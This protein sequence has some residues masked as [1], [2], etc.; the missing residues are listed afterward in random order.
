MMSCGICSK[1]QH[2]SCHDNADL[3][4]G[5]RKRNWDIEEFICQHCRPQ[6]YSSSHQQYPS[7][8]YSTAHSHAQQPQTGD[9]MTYANPTTNLSAPRAPAGYTGVQAYA[10]TIPS[11]QH[12]D[13]NFRTS[14][15]TSMSQRPYQAHSAITFAHYQPDPQG[16]STR[17]TYQR[18]LPGQHTYQQQPQYMPFSSQPQG[19]SMNPRPVQ[20]RLALGLGLLL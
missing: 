14:T 19:V 20:V 17:Q 13:H 18:D 8:Q 3:L 10:N 12:H 2:I 4:A 1:W 5:R 9:R 16:F 7:R 15:P 6:K 11:G